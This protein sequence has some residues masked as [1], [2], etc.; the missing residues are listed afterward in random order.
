VYI[1]IYAQLK[2]RRTTE[3]KKKEKGLSLAGQE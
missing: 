2:D 3:I 1:N